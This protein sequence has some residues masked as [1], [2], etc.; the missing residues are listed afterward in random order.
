LFF[1]GAQAGNRPPFTVEDRIGSQASLCDFTVHKVALWQF[2]L[3]GLRFT[4]VAP[5][6]SS[7]Y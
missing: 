5:Y 4:T 1:K 2:S 6:L 7:S 3:R